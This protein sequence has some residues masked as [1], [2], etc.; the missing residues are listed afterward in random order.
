MAAVITGGKIQL[1]NAEE[2]YLTNVLKYLIRVG[3]KI[4]YNIDG[5]LIEGPKIIKNTDIKTE[6][7]PDFLLIYKLKRWL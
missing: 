6:V 3:A 5:I 2:K 4:E 7:Y 1:L